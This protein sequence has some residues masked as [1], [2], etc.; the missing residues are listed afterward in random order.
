MRFVLVD[1][2]DR[3]EP[4][5]SADGHKI[6]ARDEDYF[7][8]HF[9]GY[10]V[11]PGVLVLESLAQLGGRLIEASVREVGGRRVLPMLVKFDR[12]RLLGQVRPGDRLDLSVELTA[13]GHSAASVVATACVKGKKTA[14]ADIMYALFDVGSNVA[15]LSEHQTA[16]LREWSDRVWRELNG[17]ERSTAPS[18]GTALVTGG[19]G[20]LGTAICHA[21]GAQGQSVA[22]HCHHN[23]AHAAAVVAGIVRENGSARVYEADLL[24][25]EAAN[26]LVERV[27]ADSG[28]IDVLVNNAGIVRDALLFSLSDD[29]LEAVLDM[30][31]KAAFRVTRAAARHM[32]RRKRGVIINISSA[33]ASR[34]GR[35]QSNYAAAKAGLEGFTR[36][37]AVELAPKGIRV[38]AV[39]PGVIESAMTR[40]IREV[41]GDE[42]LNRILL[43]RFGT[44]G[45]VASAVAFLAS[46]A[47]SYITGEVLHVDG[48][49]R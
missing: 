23:H 33:A 2:I 27:I 43:R 35:G 26:D 6:V 17:A 5:R 8:D 44:A 28:S 49:L 3:L 31:L 48:G 36:A 25:P 21:L 47:A 16:E 9:P 40:P 18:T 42:I 37:M 19:S 4:G 38:N 20:E 24:S 46:T 13:L 39:A 11:V 30:N 29:D 22:V 7:R 34:P 41:A 1:R 14:S 45:D 15:S 10:P 12:A 32:M